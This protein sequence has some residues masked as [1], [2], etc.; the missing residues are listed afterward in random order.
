[1]AAPA[2]TPWSAATATTL[3]SWARATTRSS[4]IPGDDNDIV[5]GQAGF[6]TLRFNG[7]D[8]FDA[9]S[10]EANGGRVQISAVPGGV[11]LDLD[12]IERIEIK[13]LG[14]PDEVFVE[15]LSGT[16]VKQVAIDLASLA[17]VADDAGDQVVISGTAGKDVIN[18][19]SAAGIVSI[20]GLSA[21]VTIA[22]AN[23]STCL[24]SMHPAATTPSMLRR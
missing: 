12:D 6:D 5:E 16:D 2:T 7:I 22:H 11:A 20:A 19:T 21:Q 4:G 13:A 9:I 8:G 1:M 24:A 14:G 10:V 3:R 23:T 18:F 17:G 15:N